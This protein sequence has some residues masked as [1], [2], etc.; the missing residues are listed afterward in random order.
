M[1]KLLGKI[2]PFSG[3]SQEQLAQIA[4]CCI[5]GQ[6]EQ[7]QIIYN[8]NTRARKMYIVIE[9]MVSLDDI[10]P[11]TTAFISYERRIPHE[12][13]GVAAL[14]GLKVHSLTA[15]CLEPS[16]VLEIDVECLEKVFARDADVGFKVMS[17]VAYIFYQRY[18]KAKSRLYNVFRE[19]PVRLICRDR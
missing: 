6:Y 9:G 7:N 17:E 2:S 11:D 8:Q 16:K 3:L 14:M 1:I 5:Q 12:I 15:T 4:D 10:V 19:I 13:I 18:Q